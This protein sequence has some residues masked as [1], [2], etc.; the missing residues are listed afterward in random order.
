MMIFAGLALSSILILTGPPHDGLPH[1]GPPSSEGSPERVSPSADSPEV[2][3]RVP[4]L[5]SILRQAAA[6]AQAA[7]VIVGLEAV[8]GLQVEQGTVVGQIDDRLAQAAVQARQAEVDRLRR[9]VDS[10]ID[11][12]F[13]AAAAEVAQADY[14]QVLEANRKAPGAVAAAHVRDKYLAWKKALLQAEQAQFDHDQAL[15]QLTAAEAELIAAQVD[16]DNRVIRAPLSGLVI[17]L[18]RQPGEW[19]AAGEPLFTLA[20]LDRLRVEGFLDADAVAP[21][22]IAGRR[23]LVTVQLERGREAVFAGQV[24]FVDPVVQQPGGSYKFWAEV[25]NRRSGNSWLLRPGHHGTLEILAAD[26][27]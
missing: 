14:Q 21:E 25:A 11:I 24:T 13:A 19:A 27:D 26:A 4:C 12:R 18:H 3:A 8:E 22:E 1:R 20:A 23:V 6:P 10:D 9:Q 16:R 7:G 17:E 15:L 5:A 2:I